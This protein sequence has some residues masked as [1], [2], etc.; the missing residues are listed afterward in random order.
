MIDLYHGQV[1]HLI[2]YK[3]LAVFGCVL[4]WYGLRGGVDDKSRV[5][6]HVFPNAISVKGKQRIRYDFSGHGRFVMDQDQLGR[7]FYAVANSL[8]EPGAKYFSLKRSAKIRIYPGNI[9][10]TKLEM[11]AVFHAA[12]PVF[13]DMEVTVEDEDFRGIA[14][15][16]SV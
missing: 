6:L 12:A 13:K 14:H 16:A 2:P 11:D 9:G 7:G 4:S 1:T 15:A 5:E 8:E 3:L 10:V